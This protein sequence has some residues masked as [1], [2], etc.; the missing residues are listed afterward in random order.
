MSRTEGAGGR[1]YDPATV[2]RCVRE[3]LIAIGEDPDRSGLVDTPD[4][5]AR[6]YREIFAGL[7]EDPSLHL[8]TTFDVDAS[9]LVIVKDVEFSSMC[10]HH[11]LPFLGTVS[12]AYL[13][14]N[15]RVTGLSKVARCIDGYANRPQV[16][17]RLTRQ[18]AS[19]LD[20]T[21]SPR[22][23]GVVARAEH[24]CMTIRGVRKSG[25]QTVTTAFLGEL[26][27]PERRA[28]VLELL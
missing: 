3:L 7:R 15:G 21:L 24:M 27:Q 28:E 12:V 2:R 17:E 9:D 13:P 6:S 5:V 25:A 26:D 22:G 20:S 19:A 1:A 23:V 14:S 8:R 11:L 18:I 16:Q 4:R 10:E